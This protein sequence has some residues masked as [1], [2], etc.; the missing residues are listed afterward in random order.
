MIFLTT[1]D[2]STS[3]SLSALGSI[4]FATRMAKII[5]RKS[6]K[7]TY[8]GCSASFVGSMVEE[9][10]DAV[11]LAVDAVMEEFNGED[12]PVKVNGV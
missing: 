12:R 5:A 6:G 11:K 10:M 3:S 7:P 1:T 9:E 2:P 8:V 4:D